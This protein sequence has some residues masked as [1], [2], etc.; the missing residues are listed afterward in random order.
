MACK[1][2]VKANKAKIKDKKELNRVLE[3]LKAARERAL[4]ELEQ[5]KLFN[6]LSEIRYRDLSLKYGEIFEAQTGAEAVYEIFK[7]VVND[8]DIFLVDGSVVDGSDDPCKPLAAIPRH[9]LAPC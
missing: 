1:A 7:Q 2:A 8:Q 9:P 4:D 3:N 6:V 5:I